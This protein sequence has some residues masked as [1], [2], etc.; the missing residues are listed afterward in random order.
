ML[1]IT[2]CSFFALANARPIM[3]FAYVNIVFGI[4]FWAWDNFYGGLFGIF[5]W[6]PGTLIITLFSYMLYRLIAWLLRAPVS[7]DKTGTKTA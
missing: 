4:F 7:K 5:H 2:S 6:L 3:E 1:I